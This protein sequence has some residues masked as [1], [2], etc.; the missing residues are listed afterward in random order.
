MTSPQQLLACGTSIAAREIRWTAT[1]GGVVGGQ[2]VGQS[3]D[4][5]CD[6]VRVEE[7]AETDATVAVV[8]H[9]VAQGT[10]IDRARLY[11]LRK[12]VAIA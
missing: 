7:R 9:L 5:D 4:G 1:P 8:G 3:V 10:E 11:G 12:L 2:R 6:S